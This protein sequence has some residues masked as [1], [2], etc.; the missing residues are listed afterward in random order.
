MLYLA[1][2]FKEKKDANLGPEETSIL[3]DYMSSWTI[4][5]N[6]ACEM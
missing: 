4:L 2:S 5:V 3:P 6:K 1:V